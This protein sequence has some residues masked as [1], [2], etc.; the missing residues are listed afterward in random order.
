MAFIPA[1]GTSAGQQPHPGQNAAASPAPTRTVTQP[2]PT[3]TVHTTVTPPAPANSG[4]TPPADGGTTPP[5]AA[6]SPEIIANFSG[7]GDQDTGS[8]TA[9]DTWHLSWAYWGCPDPPSNFQ[10]SEYNTDGSPDISGVD[11]NELGSGRGPVA[12]T[13]HGDGGSHY[14]QVTTEDCSW[15]LVVVSGQG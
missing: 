8:F 12:T 7:S 10:V 1:C 6:S 2:G 9:P 5:P 4:T 14:F 11:V 3:A 13:A 15:D